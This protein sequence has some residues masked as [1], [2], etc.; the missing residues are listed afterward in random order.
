[1]QALYQWQLGAQE[2]DL[3]ADQFRSGELL[4]GADLEFFDAAF[5]GVTTRHEH[6]DL[7]LGG[8]ARH[9]PYA[10]RLLHIA[11]LPRP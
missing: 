3:V 8:R 11:G 4:A 2:P 5:A 1:M 10:R 9:E 7:A 6:L